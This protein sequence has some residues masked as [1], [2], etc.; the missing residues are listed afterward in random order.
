MA[1]KRAK[2]QDIAVK[3]RQ[4]EVLEGQGKSVS[5][6]VAGVGI[7]RLTS[8][9][10]ASAIRDGKLVSL[11]RNDAPEPLP[12]HL[13][14][15]GPPWLPMKMRSFIDFAIPRRRASLSKIENV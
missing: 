2:A 4:V 11:L 12:V 7:A 8:Y 9:Q 3:L 13:V 1:G 14:H 6:A 15:T 10:A 5:E